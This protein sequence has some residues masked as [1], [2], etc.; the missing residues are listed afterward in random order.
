MSARSM[1]I[2]DS[3]QFDRKLLEELFSLADSL[4]GK[5][6][7]SLKGKILATLFYEPSTRTRLSFESAMH[8]LGGSVITTENARES[9]SAVKGE[10]LEDTIRVVDNYAD[11]IALRHPDAGAAAHAASV[12]EVPIINAGD[13]SQHPSQSLIDLYTIHRELKRMD[14]FHIAF[15]GNL[16]YYRTAQSLASVL[17]NHTSVRMTF[18]SAPELKMKP[19]ILSELASKNV[20]VSETEDMASVLKDADVIYQTRIAKE[21]IPDASVYEKLK[22]RYKISRADADQMKAGAIIMHPLPRVGEIEP[23]VDSSPHVAYFRQAG[24]G[25][26]VRMAL[27]ATLVK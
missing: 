9:S 24:Y 5:R 25:V 14:D 15:V 12:S 19:E 4:D 27:L 11:V 22:D 8:R 13:G 18:V 10:T 2:T 1:H 20:K 21:W 16:A 17:G 3:K 6:N 26:T 23:D 7:D